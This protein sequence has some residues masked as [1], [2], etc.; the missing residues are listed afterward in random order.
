VR[1]PISYGIFEMQPGAVRHFQAA[2][3]R[4]CP[5]YID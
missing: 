4:R 3:G 5:V 2:S 1:T